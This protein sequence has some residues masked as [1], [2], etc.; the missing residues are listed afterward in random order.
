MTKDNFDEA[1]ANAEAKAVYE[2]GVQTLEEMGAIDMISQA[3]KVI[4]HAKVEMHLD[5]E[6][7]GRGFSPEVHLRGEEVIVVENEGKPDEYMKSTQNILRV[8]GLRTMP[9]R[10]SVDVWQSKTDSR[11]NRFSSG[12]QLWDANI[13]CDSRRTLGRE[14]LEGIQHIQPID[15]ATKQKL[16]EVL[17]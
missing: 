4:P 14:M 11:G 8:V 7:W 6:R 9:G 2:K 10:V 16:Q 15:T 12:W 1:K 5:F 13:T 3:A 17:V